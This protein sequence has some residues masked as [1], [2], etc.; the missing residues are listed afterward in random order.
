[1]LDSVREAILN[2]YELRCGA[3][4]DRGEL[5]RMMGA[6][7]WLTAREAV[8]LGL[9]DGVLF[10]ESAAPQDV[11]NAAGAGLRALGCGGV[12]DIAALRAEYRRARAA[13]PPNTDNW[14]ARARLDIE[15]NRFLI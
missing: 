6:E 2:A 10:E 4:A 11:M 14:Q 5:R 9:A 15:H 7:T 13:A 12:P 1:M 8:E 3:R